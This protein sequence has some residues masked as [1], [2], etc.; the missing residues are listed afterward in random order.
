MNPKPQSLTAAVSSRVGRGVL[1][2]ATNVS[3]PSLILTPE[4]M[5]GVS[6]TAKVAQSPHNLYKYPARFAPE[7]ARETIRAFSR[8][9]DLVLDPFCGGGT[10]L[11]EAIALGR[12]A[13]GFDISALACF[14]AKTKTTPL[15]VHDERVLRDWSTGLQLSSLSTSLLTWQQ[16]DTDDGYYRRNLPSSALA[17]LSSVINQLERLPRHRQR[18]FARLV[19]LAVGQW[20]LDCKKRLPD[21]DEMLQHFV[22]QLIEQIVA[23]RRYTWTTALRIGIPNRQLESLR[24]VVRASSES[25]GESGRA[26]RA[27]ASLVV[28]SPPYPGVHMLYHR[29]QL[30]G[31]RET[32]APFL[33]ADCR[34]G[35]GTS[36]YCLGNRHEQG[37]KTYYERLTKVFAA[38]RSRLRPDAMVVQMVAF[39]QPEWQLPAFLR[40]MKIAGYAEAPVHAEIELG[41]DGRVWRTVPGRRWYAATSKRTNAAGNEVVL[42]HRPV[43]L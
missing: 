37:L 42:F 27:K 9:G 8:P 2:N 20:A 15:S 10:S 43:A 28:T 22:A 3:A 21:A 11:I 40:A 41:P 13:V 1:H 36:F 34:D 29:W 31:R 32:P 7:F 17:F 16:F 23:F 5:A 24:M 39:N 30:F 12:R 14:L 35:D 38:V 25:C 6:S 26:P 18:R 4:F 33:I 19:L